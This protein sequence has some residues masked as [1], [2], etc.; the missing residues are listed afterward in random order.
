MVV[1]GGHS[2]GFCICC[3]VV[4][5][6]FFVSWKRHL[7]VYRS[8]YHCLSR[9]DK[10]YVSL[11]DCRI[12]LEGFYENYKRKARR[13]RI[14][15]GTYEFRQHR[16]LKIVDEPYFLTVCCFLFL[17]PDLGQL[18]YS[19]SMPIVSGHNKRCSTTLIHG[20]NIS[21]SRQ[22]KLKTFYLIIKCCGVQGWS[23]TIKRKNN[24]M[25]K[26]SFD[27]NAWFV[28]CIPLNVILSR[29]SSGF[30]I[31][32]CLYHA[33]TS[34]AEDQSHRWWLDRKRKPRMISLCHQG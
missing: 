17:F 9:E 7:A 30:F 13:S 2:F 16:K 4:V 8:V 6:S 5:F 19:T 34:L 10:E 20:V 27:F 12:R 11:L 33:D 28:R 24:G 32:R 23:V 21:S 22:K 26:T 14:Y 1:G 29:M 15:K 31:L 3:V 25:S 18:T